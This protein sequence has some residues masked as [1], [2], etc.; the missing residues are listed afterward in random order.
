MGHLVFLSVSPFSGL[1]RTLDASKQTDRRTDESPLPSD[2][3]RPYLQAIRAEDRATLGS[4]PSADTGPKLKMLQGPG[5][6]GPSCCVSFG[7]YALNPGGCRGAEPPCL[8]QA[9]IRQPCQLREPYTNTGNGRSTDGIWC[10]IWHLFRDGRGNVFHDLFTHLHGLF[11]RDRRDERSTD[12]TAATAEEG[13]DSRRK[14]GRREFRTAPI[15][16]ECVRISVFQCRL[17]NE[18]EPGAVL[19]LKN[20]NAS[21]RPHILNRAGTADAEQEGAGQTKTEDQASDSAAP[22]FFLPVLYRLRE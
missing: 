17:G 7:P 6:P 9:K 12:P 20:G 4:D 3:R 8:L 22:A 5:I 13:G 19:A 16:P 15:R 11:R 21:I 14:F 1:S 18:D 10:G 2:G